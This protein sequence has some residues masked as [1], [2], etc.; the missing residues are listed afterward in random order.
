MG[1]PRASRSLM[2]TAANADKST[3]WIV[4]P[5]ALAVLEQVFSMERFPTRQLRAS[6]AA[7]LAVNPRQV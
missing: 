7:D 4:A 1:R 2:V 5:A 3:R 6:L